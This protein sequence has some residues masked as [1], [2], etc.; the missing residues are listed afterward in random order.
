MAKK[1]K[2]NKNFDSKD[3][4]DMLSAFTDPPKKEEPPI[5]PIPPPKV[6][7]DPTWEDK[8]YFQQES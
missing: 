8:V 4:G 3:G 6:V 5:E 2:K 7:S 1:K